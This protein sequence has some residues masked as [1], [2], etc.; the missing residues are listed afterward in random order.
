[1]ENCLIKKRI[2]QSGQ[3]QKLNYPPDTKVSLTIFSFSYYVYNMS[4]K[5]K[6][7]MLFS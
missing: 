7:L 1:M 5:L 2:I 4:C 6:L 3:K